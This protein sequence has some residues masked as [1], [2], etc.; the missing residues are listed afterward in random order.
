MV[1]ILLIKQPKLW[2]PMGVTSRADA[3]VENVSFHVLAI[4]IQNIY[5]NQT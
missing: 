4:E 3:V 5:E 2:R 1:S